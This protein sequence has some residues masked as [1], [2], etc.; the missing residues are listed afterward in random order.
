[1]NKHVVLNASVLSAITVSMAMFGTAVAVADNYAG[2]TY[3]DAAAGLNKAGLTPIIATKVGEMLPRDQCVVIRS[4][5]PQRLTITAGKKQTFGK[6]TDTVLLFLNCETPIASA[7]RP[8]NSAASP[9]GKAAKAAA[10]SNGK[11]SAPKR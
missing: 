10:V 7:G 5:Q 4:E 1:M 11:P 2:M 8:G 9:E 3:A 6:V